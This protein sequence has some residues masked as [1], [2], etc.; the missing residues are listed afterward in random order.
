MACAAHRVSRSEGETTVTRE[1]LNRACQ[2]EQI[3]SL[4]LG[5]TERQY[6]A[7]VSEGPT[8]LNVI[9]SRIG[10]P[11]RTI[12]EVTEPFLIRVGLIVK[13]QQGRQLT[14]FGREH[15]AQNCTVIG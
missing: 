4:G 11:A 12:A 5:P 6:L 7:I 14:A 2:L 3:D 13:D 9:A 15:L 8:R 1:H 10:L